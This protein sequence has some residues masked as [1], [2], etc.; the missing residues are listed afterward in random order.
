MRRLA[1]QTLAV[2]VYYSGI[3][4]FI[5]WLFVQFTGHREPRVLMYHRVIS[6]PFAATEFTQPGISVSTRTFEKQ[7]KYLK[8]RFRIVST[9]EHREFLKAISADKEP[10]V[11]ITF[12]DGW[13][14]NLENAYPIL[15][16]S[17]ASATIFVCSDFVGTKLKFWFHSIGYYVLKGKITVETIN[18]I[19]NGITHEQAQSLSAR[20]SDRELV[21]QLL[22]RAKSLSPDQVELLIQRLKEIS[23]LND[24]EWNDHAFVADWNSLRHLDPNVITIGSHGCSHKLLTAVSSAEAAAEI[25][26]SKTKIESELG[27][28]VE[29]FAYPNGDYDDN[30]KSLVAAAGYGSA[31]AVG[32]NQPSKDRFAIGRIGIHEGSSLGVGNKFSRAIFAMQLSPAIRKLNSRKQS[33]Y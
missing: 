17:A 10:R 9:A 31:Y 20:L 7:I 27:R 14:D 2:C 21:D 22:A 33:G 1:K 18:G 28:N 11:V 6:D 26:E 12:D 16:S 19:L 32:E 29:S 23:G 5:D 8:K 15:K 25:G 24:P 30:I 13:R 3:L 4:K